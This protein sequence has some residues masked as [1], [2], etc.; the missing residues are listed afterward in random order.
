[1][2][3]EPT[4]MVLSSMDRVRW[5]AAF[6]LLAVGVAGFYFF[7]DQALLYRVLGV[8][9]LAGI[10]AWV[11]LGS[12]QGEHF[13][14]FMREARVEVRKMVWPTRPETLQTSLVVFVAVIIMAL[15]LWLLDRLLSW[16]ITLFLGG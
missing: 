10:A 7:V 6:V 1:M 3:K 14:G 8:V 4:G 11:A 12:E 16:A 15:F 2:A 13:R 9:A 5:S